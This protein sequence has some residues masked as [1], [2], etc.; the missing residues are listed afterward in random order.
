MRPFTGAQGLTLARYEAEVNVPIGQE[1]AFD[2]WLD[3]G[4]YPQWQGGVI[5]AV[6]ASGPLDQP[7]TTFRLDHGPGMKRTVTVLEANR[8]NSILMRQHGLGVAD[9]TLVTFSPLGDGSTRVRATI[10]LRV[11]LGSF[12]RLLER[13]SRGS[14]TKEVQKE[15][16][17]YAAVA[18]RRQAEPSAGEMHSVDSGAGHRL[19]TVLEVEPDVVH[20]LVHP[21]FSPR[22]IGDPT[23]FLDARSKMS[24]PLGLRPI[25]PSVRAAAR[26]VETG[27][28]LLRLDGGIG[29]PHVALTRG[30]FTD[31]LPRQVVQPQEPQTRDHP[32]IASWRAS[33]GPLLG[34]DLDA[35]I[36]PLVTFE[37]EQGI[38]VAK[39]LHVDAGGVHVR[40]YSDRW[41]VCPPEV[42]PWALRL[43]PVN[44]E[45]PG[46]HPFGIGHLPLSRS[47]FLARR[48]IFNRLAMRGGE[49]LE[50]YRMWREAKGGYFS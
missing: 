12:G 16:N 40:L 26:L 47:A 30:A 33:T 25:D 14:S 48:P 39:L 7:G 5:R 3:A 36:C 18:G 29:I 23:P 34:R 46:G 19:V 17:R 31:A 27:Q 50:G 6:E 41:A 1:A 49:E 24:D 10:D 44:A 38:A 20:V 4:R 11:G 13:I 37:G 43:E 35:S 9:E 2:L 28:S 15:L 8:P 45:E 42:N 22:P 32:E 21:G